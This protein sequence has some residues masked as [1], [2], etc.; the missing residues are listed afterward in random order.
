MTY[1]IPHANTQVYIPSEKGCHA[2]CFEDVI[3]AVLFSVEHMPERLGG[4]NCFL[5][6]SINAD[7]C[8]KPENVLE[9]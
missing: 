7:C 9:N 6:D 4:G 8:W 2:V 5:V 1:V 3:K